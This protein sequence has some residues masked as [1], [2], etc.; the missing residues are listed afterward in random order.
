MMQILKR[1]KQYTPPIFADLLLALPDGKMYRVDVEQ[2]GW[3]K[4]AEPLLDI[5][6]RAGLIR[7]GDKEPAVWI[8][9]NGKRPQYLS[10]VIRTINMSGGGSEQARVAG[11]ICGETSVWLHKD[12]LVEVGPEPS[13]R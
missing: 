7:R 13:F 4:D 10:R 6:K 2:S 8:S 12:G 11:L 5:V 1:S 3:L 9:M